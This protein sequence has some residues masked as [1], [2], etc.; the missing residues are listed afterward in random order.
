[1]KAGRTAAYLAG[2][3]A[4]AGLVGVA[5]D[6]RSFP[7]VVKKGETL[8]D[9]ATRFYGR[10]ELE[11][12]LV[13]ANAL[14]VQNGAAIVPGV[15]LEIPA[16]HHHVVAKGDTWESL[17]DRYLG[18]RRRAEALA[19]AN[20]TWPWLPPDV[21]REVRIPFN[22]R[23]VVKRGD[24]TP[25]IAY[26]FLEKRDDAYLLDRYND[27]GGEAVEPG[28]VILVPLA[29]LEL[30]DEGK[31]AARE[32]LE[33]TMTEGGGDDRDA[34]DAATV[35]IPELERLVHGGDYVEAIAKGSALL[36]SGRLTV[37]EIA[38]IQRQLVEAY[39]ALGEDALAES[40][41]RK[42]READ[43]ESELDPVLLSPKILRACTEALIATPSA[44]RPLPSAE[45]SASVSAAPSVRAPA[46]TRPR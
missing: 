31:R 14:D 19:V 7:Y 8:A 2:L 42:Y 26:R 17:A 12:V 13:P 5:S 23:Y 36:G 37:V 22:L 10:V 39:V 11:R 16:V 35:A 46:P 33:Y 1:M 34:Q 4:L 30:T 24:S 32:G 6:A 21:G 15:R 27:L 20:D 25:S 3:L 28:D 43:P 9:I 44:P 18:G 40:A 41:C 38:R 45:P 29:D